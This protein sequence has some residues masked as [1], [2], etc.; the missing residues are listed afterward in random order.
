M[1]RGP[2]GEK[3]KK[4]NEKKKIVCVQCNDNSVVIVPSNQFGVVPVLTTKRYSMK[5]KSKVDIHHP[6]VI[7]MFNKHMGGFDQMVK[8]IAKYRIGFRGNKWICPFYFG[9][10]M[11]AWIMLSYSR[12]YMDVRVT[13]GY[14]NFEEVWSIPTSSSTILSIIHIRITSA[15]WSAHNYMQS[16]SKMV[17]AL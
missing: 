4:I 1:L 3:W 2:F 6:N 16:A 10:W 8:S 12:E 17:Y 15:I 14:G 7:N 11:S 13:S 9:W 5:D